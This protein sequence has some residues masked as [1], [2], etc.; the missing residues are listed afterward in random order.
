MLCVVFDTRFLERGTQQ[1]RTSSLFHPVIP[2]PSCSA[3]SSP[4][5]RNGHVLEGLQWRHR[6]FIASLRM[7][8]AS[9][10]RLSTHH[11]GE[12]LLIIST[13]INRS[14]LRLGR[15]WPTTQLVVKAYDPD[16]KQTTLR[17]INVSNFAPCDDK[18]SSKSDQF[19]VSH[20]STLGGEFEESYSILGRFGDDFQVSVDIKRPSAIPGF[21]IGK[22]P[23]GGFSYFGRNVEKPKGYVVHRFWP[24]FHSS[25]IVV[26][27]SRAT[28]FT[29]PGMFV[30]AIQGMRPNLVASSWNFAHF[31]SDEHGG[32]SAIQMELTTIDTYGKK[33]EGSGKVVVNVG[34][35]VVGGKLAAVTA[36]TKWPGEPVA[37][38]PPV[39]SR[40][41]HHD[42]S[43]D[44]F[45]GYDVPSTIT[46]HW[47]GP[48]VVAGVEGNLS[49]DLS[50]EVGKPGKEIGLIEKVDVLAEIPGFVKAVVN[51]VAGAKPYIYQVC[52]PIISFSRPLTIIFSGSTPRR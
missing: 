17:S 42:K 12:F 28:S 29:G 13:A 32:V 9:W 27:N 39:L 40:A 37:D 35:L 41:V 2:I 50:V 22:G 19:T 47:A 5:T 48:S 38:K 44:S 14:C 36:E 45:T 25:G 51:Y 3:N 11:S 10:C 16:T 20:K 31:Q 46:F 1:H 8:Q 7:G 34:S 21:K 18:R 26:N 15:L 30:H 23:K 52:F 6:S 43:L 33:G 4:R 49:A 24:R